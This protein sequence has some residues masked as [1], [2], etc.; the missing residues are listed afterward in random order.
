M[1]K[2]HIP[3][4]ILAFA[5][6]LL[7]LILDNSAA[8]AGQNGPVVAPAPAK[9]EPGSWVKGFLLY[10]DQYAG[11]DSTEQAWELRKKALLDYGAYADA[12]NEVSLRE[13][14][15]GDDP[16]SRAI[17]RGKTA[18]VFHQLRRLA[19]EERF[20]SISGLLA[21]EAVSAT[22]S[23]DDI[24]KL[25]EKETGKDLGWFFQQWVDRK[26]LPD[27]RVENAAVR[28]NGS[29]FEVSFDLVQKGDV[30]VLDVPVVISFI[31]GG[32]KTETVKLDA[33]KKHV[34]LDVDEEPLMAAIDRGYDVPRKLTEAET[35]PLL[36][37]V[38]SEEKPLLLL[39]EGKVELYAGVIDAWKKRGA[40]ERKAGSIR[41]ADI[42]A[43]SLIVLGA[44]NPLV[45]RL[46]GKIKPGADELNLTARKNPWNAE[47]V[48]VI[49]EARTAA[50]ADDALRSAIEYGDCSSLAID[51]GGIGT[52]TTAESERGIQLGLREEPSAVVVSAL[53]SFS[54]VIEGVTGKKIVYVGEYHDR[55]AH[56]MTQLQVI[57]GLYRKNPKLAIGMEMFQRPFQPVLDDYI[58]GKIEE[59]EFLK[60][61][62][63]FKRWSF[64]YNLYKPILDFARAAKIPVVALNLRREI[65]EKVSR[66]GMDVLTDDEKKEVPREMD[67]SDTEYRDRLKQ[68]SSQHKGR[69]EKSFDFFFQAQ[70]LWDETMSMSIDEY[71][72]KNPDRQVVVIVGQG[73]LLYGSGIPKRTLRRNGYEYATIL[74]DADAD[75]DI[76]DYLVFPEALDGVKTPR[77]MV[78]L[79]EV[80]EKIIVADLPEDSIS[81]KA[82]IKAG[83]TLVSLDGVLIKTMDD[84]KIELFYKKQGD[85]VSVKV[86]RKRFLLG[87]REMEFDVKLP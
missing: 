68:V 57:K 39:P 87:D 73:H 56:H 13:F 10:R 20:S 54:H 14:R 21:G 65:I 61:S 9:A 48:V 50:R 47:K 53:K 58:S 74:N 85:I 86:T 27:L 24:W 62:E 1:K 4:V 26:G 17:G 52:R 37:K 80:G 72:R 49:V 28:W 76:G 44:D 36:A 8:A 15:D 55:L 40:E 30:Y 43:S 60:K 71:L 2:Y 38:V 45:T 79:K 59:R 18:M 32:S 16:A 64:D 31:R 83:D 42:R 11:K 69:S 6:N 35:P 23:W 25:S 78:V 33:E 66:E 77:L 51:S 5:M 70:I 34:V 81:R 12:K 63:Y 84:L 3:L 75:L 67:F 19:G 41:D 82:G 7:P 22:S 29:G 46:Y